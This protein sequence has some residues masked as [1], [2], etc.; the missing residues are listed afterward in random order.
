MAQRNKPEDYT[1]VK[2]KRYRITN[3]A[4]RQTYEASA[5]SADEACRKLGWLIGDC[6]VEEI[7][8]G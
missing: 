4:T 7:G 1:L 2:A 5:L 6:F 8:V 3:R